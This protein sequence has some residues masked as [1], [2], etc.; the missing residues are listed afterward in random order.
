[1][2]MAKMVFPYEIKNVTEEEDKLAK[3]YYKGEMC[4]TS[5]CLCQYLSMYC[6]IDLKRHCKRRARDGA[7]RHI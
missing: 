4:R 3:K 2:K 1:D 7:C 6:E 5:L